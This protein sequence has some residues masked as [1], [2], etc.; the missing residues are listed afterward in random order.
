MIHD[1][2]RSTYNAAETALYPGLANG[3]TAEPNN[4]IDILSNGFKVRA[5]GGSNPN[6]NPSSGTVVYAA[7]AEHPF[8]SNARAR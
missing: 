5:A 6:I 8:A 1:T 4:K 7:F 3:D 2:A